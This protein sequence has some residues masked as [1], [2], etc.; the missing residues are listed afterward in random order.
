MVEPADTSHVKQH[1][2]KYSL[3]GAKRMQSRNIHKGHKTLTASPSQHYSPPMQKLLGAL[4]GQLYIDMG[5]FKKEI[6]VFDNRSSNGV[7]AELQ[8]LL[9]PFCRLIFNFADTYEVLPGRIRKSAVQSVEKLSGDMMRFDKDYSQL[10][11]IV[12]ITRPLHII[13]CDLIGAV[14]WFVRQ[15]TLLQNSSAMTSKNGQCKIALTHRPKDWALREAFRNLTLEHQAKKGLDK[16]I[17]FKWFVKELNDLNRQTGVN[18][19][20][21]ERTYRNLKNSWRSGNF[22]QII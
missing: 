16:F 18:L 14:D 4:L 6:E 21:S 7:P 5:I 10:R 13:I 19:K 11:R 17:Q 3:K 22:N 20:C 1:H 12:Q 8:T 9:T 2:T 15:H